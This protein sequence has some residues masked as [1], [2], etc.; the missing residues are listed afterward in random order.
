MAAPVKKFRK[1]GSA[2]LRGVFSIRHLYVM[3]RSGAVCAVKYDHDRPLHSGLRNERVKEHLIH[4]IS[5]FHQVRIA[6]NINEIPQ[7]LDAPGHNE[8]GRDL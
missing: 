4:S 7:K 8:G 5:S 1:T 6:P 3:G 2:A